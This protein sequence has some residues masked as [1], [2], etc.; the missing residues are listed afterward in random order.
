[1]WLYLDAARSLLKLLMQVCPEGY[2][3]IHAQCSVPAALV[4]GSR[5][6][7]L[8]KVVMMQA[9]RCNIL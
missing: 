7:L 5:Q 2:F 8:H 9:V 3:V 6:E 1:L 4:E